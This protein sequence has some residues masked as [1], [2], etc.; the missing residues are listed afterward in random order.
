MAEEAGASWD[1]VS[2]NYLQNLGV[3]L[4]RGR[5]FSAADNEH[6][7]LVAVVNAIALVLGT[8]FTRVAVGLVLGLPL[9]VGAGRLISAQLYGVS[10]WDPL[11]LALAVASLAACAFVAAIIPAARAAAV[12]PI[13]AL[14][15]E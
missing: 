1:R 14:R 10:F 4:L 7:A 5:H 13:S 11:A 8:A 15:A 6:S 2:A 9:A 12:S 3:P